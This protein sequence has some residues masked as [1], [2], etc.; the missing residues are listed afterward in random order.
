MRKHDSKVD[1]GRSDVLRMGWVRRMNK[2]YG[3]GQSRE[4]QV[5]KGCRGILYI[6]WIVVGCDV[7]AERLALV[8]GR[9][10]SMDDVCAY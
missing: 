2:A 3:C 8:D 6:Y 1:M 9:G 5:V 4:E 7:R 10:W